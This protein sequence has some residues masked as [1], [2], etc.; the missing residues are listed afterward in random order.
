MNASQKDQSKMD[1]ILHHLNKII[2]SKVLKGQAPHRSFKNST[3]HWK[4]SDIILCQQRLT[5]AE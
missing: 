2:F 5:K 1:M 3:K 4:K